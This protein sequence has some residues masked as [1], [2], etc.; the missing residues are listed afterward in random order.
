MELLNR[1]LR[2]FASG[3][4][5]GQMRHRAAVDWYTSSSWASRCWVAAGCAS[6]L[7]HAMW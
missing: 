5:L 6:K 2:D 7:S 1:L 4:L 3:M